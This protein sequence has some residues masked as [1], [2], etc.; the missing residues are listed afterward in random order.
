VT[1]KAWLES[2]EREIAERWL[3][4]LRL[5]PQTAREGEGRLLEEMVYHL[6]SFLPA[7]F[8]DCRERGL[9]VWQHG[10]HLFGSVA[11]KRGLAAGEVV[12]EFQLLRGVVLRM[13]LLEFVP[14]SAQE[15]SGR[16]NSHMEFLALNKILDQAVS[17]AT[18]SYTDDLFFT[19]LQGSGVSE[20][21]TPELSE[22]ILLQLEA[23]RDELGC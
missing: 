15:G 12:E 6:V 13:Y 21:V 17:R 10:A 3:Q 7:C 19:H 8:G 2:R 9:E 14:R 16:S 18:I 5:I 11:L 1:L 4:E 23:F 20:V 22:E